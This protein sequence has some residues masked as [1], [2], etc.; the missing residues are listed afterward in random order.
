MT[1]C[2]KFNTSLYKLN[3]FLILFFTPLNIS[4][5][6]ET[7]ESIRSIHI[8]PTEINFAFPQNKVFEFADRKSLEEFWVKYSR[9]INA[10]APEIEISW[11]KENLIAI[12]W[13]SRDQI[14]RMPA[15]TNFE[16]RD[17]KLHLHYFLVEP[18]YGII[19]DI[20]PATFWTI[21]KEKR[22]KLQELKIE[23]SPAK[24]ECL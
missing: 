11:D 1:S 16:H 8:R 10:K 18:C 12:F 4:L 3:L 13:E 22:E 23:T 2:V 15:L 19:T 7:I 21:S 20:S 17:E 9:I 5:A 14:I 24:E 6:S